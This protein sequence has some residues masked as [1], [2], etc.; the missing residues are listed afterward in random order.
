MRLLHACIVCLLLAASFAAGAEGYRIGERLAPGTEPARPA[1]REI[2]WDNLVPEDWDP[3]AEFKGLDLGSLRD[4]DPRAQA[5]LEKMRAAWDAAPVETAL[6]GKAIR[7]A[8]FV[9]PLERKGKLV[10]ELLLVPYF[11]ACIHTP[12]PPANQ[13]I[14]VVLNKPTGDVRMMDA[15]WVTG[16]LKV[17]RG[18]SGMGVFGYRLRADGLERYRPK[19]Q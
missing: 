11:G 15:F 19:G 18:D 12:P 17:A 14:H 4:G 3:M 7:L 6:D 10:S 5:A 9:I 2:Q 8:G 13:T 1:Y 16:V